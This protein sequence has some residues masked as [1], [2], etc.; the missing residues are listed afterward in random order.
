MIPDIERMAREAGIEW[1]GDS[2]FYAEPGELA[3]FCA[4]VQAAE[5]AANHNDDLAYTSNQVAAIIDAKVAAERERCAKLCDLECAQFGGVANGRMATE[6]G[7]LVHESMAAGAMNC[8]EAIR[9]GG[10]P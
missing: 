5:R 7:K 1:D 4:L 10:T 2:L 9:A 6:F 8:A 3:R